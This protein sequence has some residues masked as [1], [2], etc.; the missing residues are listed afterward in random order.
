M[1]IAHL[2][3]LQYLYVGIENKLV[4]QANAAKNLGLNIDYIILNEEKEFQVDNLIYKKITYP[5]NTLKMKI[6]KRF[7]KFSL[8]NDSIDLSEYDAI[9]I[10]Y[11]RPI[12]YDW[13][14]FIDQYPNKIITE[15]H[16]IAL[17]E[18]ISKITIGNLL[19]F[20]QEYL[21]SKKLKSQAIGLI[22]VTNEISRE[23]SR[24]NMTLKIQTVSN[25]IDVT[26]VNFTKFIP[27]D[28]KSLTMTIVAS[29][30]APWHGLD[31]L[32][33]SLL[34]YDT[35][36]I[37]VL[38]LVGEYIS[39][40]DKIT[41]DE[42]NSTNPNI[43]IKILGPKRGKEL[44]DIFSKSTLAIG[45]LA[46]YRQKLEEAC[47]LKIREYMARGIPF[48]YSAK[49]PDIEQNSSFSL[50][51]SNDNKPIDFNKIIEFV[52]KVSSQKGI[53]EEM[54]KY[55]L[56]NVDWKIKVRQMYKFILEIKK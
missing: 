54:R 41:I 25:G 4:E 35:H 44:D 50:E 33:K 15:H 6:M 16:A 20:V 10:R 52:E 38:N 31:K 56:K 53:S 5:K 2:N 28:G 37:I 14:K 43:T 24:R 49:D 26:K 8:I 3:I 18:T 47:A 27:F 12:S 7:F 13:K 39:D 11:P 9:V 19:N 30:F 23:E 55:A 34:V 29:E 1:K 32:L 40:K 48:I 36:I 46:I 22:G 51:L 42:I 45:S 21:N 17:P